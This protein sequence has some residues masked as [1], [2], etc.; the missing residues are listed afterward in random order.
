MARLLL[1]YDTGRPE[2][3]DLMTAA[4]QVHYR[5]G[6]GRGAFFI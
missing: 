4:G 5:D 2:Y 3:Q 1:E 6:L